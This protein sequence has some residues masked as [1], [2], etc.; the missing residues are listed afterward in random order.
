MSATYDGEIRIDTRIDE[1]G[2]NKGVNNINNGFSKLTQSVKGFGKAAALAFVVAEVYKYG[3]E[4]S[5]LAISVEASMQRVNDIFGQSAYIFSSFAENVAFSLGMSKKSAYEYA[6][7]YGNL[8]SGMTASTE[9]NAKLTMKYLNASAVVSS[10]TGRTMQDVMERMRSGILGNTEAIEDLGIEARVGML[11]MTDAF[12]TIADG[13]SWEKLN[14]QEQQQIRMLGILEQAHKKYGDAVSIN[15][16]LVRSQ[17]AAAMEDL[18]LSMGS[19]LNVVIIPMIQA[20][21]Q[22]VQLLNAIFVAIFGKGIVTQEQLAKSSNKAAKGQVKLADGT[23]KAAKAAEG[24]L[25]SFDELNILQQ[26]MAESTTGGAVS[27]GAGAGELEKIEMPE[28]KAPEIKFEIPKGLEDVI[29]KFIE[30]KEAFKGLGERVA[31]LWDQSGL[32]EILK[33]IG[34]VALIVALN[35]LTTAIRILTGGIDIVSG[36]IMFWTGLLTGDFDN[37]IEGA[38]LALKGFGEIIEAVFIFILGKEAYEAVKTFVKDFGEK[39]VEWWTQH[40]APWFT[41]ERW[42]ALWSTVQTAFTDGWNLIVE[43]WKTS[44][45]SAWYD[46]EVKPHT[47][48]FKAWWVQTKKEFQV[49]WD[50]IVKWWQTSALVVW[51]EQDVKPWFTTEKWTTLLTNVKS[52]FENTFTA[53]KNTVGDTFKG[54]INKML[55]GINYLIE[56]LNEIHFEVPEWVP[57]MGGKSWGINIPKV[58]YLAKGAVIQP[59]NPFMAVLGDQP[60]GLNIETPLETMLEAFKGALAEMG[61]NNSGGTVVLEL[62][63]KVLGRAVIPSI[64]YAKKQKGV[65]LVMGVV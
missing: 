10:K 3:K 22:F 51:F 53:I 1:N 15:S 14:F 28:V 37:A 18:K 7:V 49:G 31:F 35:A 5:N 54:M 65:S 46:T 44:G 2:F 19:V 30:L 50:N 6:A 64:E 21:T 36:S 34:E 8:F 27:G 48:K 23:K 13:R 9:E 39:M 40:V 43:W 20:L 42:L 16:V 45:M 4:I 57:G 60:T 56:K 11:E 63:G 25:A 26:E 47:D 58:P 12:A 59:N 41:M 24:A 17:F 33:V 62:D 29:A 38:K 61:G 32:K 52:A 55:E